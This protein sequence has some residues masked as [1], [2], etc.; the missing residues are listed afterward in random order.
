MKAKKDKLMRKIDMSMLNTITSSSFQKN[1]EAIVYV[2]SLTDATNYFQ[3]NDIKII[4]TYPFIN[5][6]CVLSDTHTIYRLSKLDIVSYISSHAKVKTMVDLSKKVLKLDTQ[7]SGK[8][9]TVAYIDTGIRPHLDFVLGINRI[10]KFVDLVENKELPYDDNGHGTFVSGVGSGNGKLSKGKFKGFAPNSNIVSIKALDK[11]GEAGASKILQAMQ[12]IYSNRKEY[13]IKVVCMSFGSEPLGYNDP[14]MKGAE[15]LWKAGIVVVTAAG[16]SGPEHESIKSPGVSPKIITVGGL[17]D[18]RFDDGTINPNFYEIANFSSR[19]PALKRY[20]PDVVSPAIDI[21][22][23][24]SKNGLYTTLSGTSV[25]TPMI[26]GLIALAFEKNKYLKPD[27]I[28][29]MLLAS[30][31]PITFNKNFEGYGLVN[32]SKFISFVPNLK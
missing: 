27:Q 26:A 3:K 4:S 32:A 2:S 6:L 20:K 19:G 9:V 28:K 1:I 21:V 8:D 13:N 24:K 5:A 30:C 16:N 29:K 12:W 17:N 18:N 15:M 7:L 31:R 25:A 11:N 23:C 10:I 14:I 22:S